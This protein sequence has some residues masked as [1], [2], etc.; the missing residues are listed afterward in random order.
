MQPQS[1][2]TNSPQPG[3][4]VRLAAPGQAQAFEPGGFWIRLVARF[5]DGLIIGV[6]TV[7][8]AI[9]FGI[10]MGI[11]G[12]SNGSNAPSAA[13]GGVAIILQLLNFVISLGATYGYYGWFYRNKGATPGKLLFGLKVVD[14]T[15]GTYLGWGQVFMREFVGWFVD[16]I[17][18]FIGLLM[19]GFRSDKRAL[20]DL[21]AGTQVLRAKK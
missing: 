10:I 8:V 7:P 16:G 20:H 17:T 21:I 12:V 4:P 18:L 9:V 2:G 14:S 5:I 3:S 1:V 13:M 6:I 11:M 19:A 15:T